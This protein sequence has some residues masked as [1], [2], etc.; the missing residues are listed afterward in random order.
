MRRQLAKAKL[1]VALLALAI[2]GCTGSPTEVS[3][4]EPST[5]QTSDT[6]ANA[7]TPAEA[8]LALDDAVDAFMAQESV[9]FTL[10]AE[11]VIDDDVTKI[12]GSGVWT[13]KPLAWKSTLTY[14][15]PRWAQDPLS[16]ERELD[17]IYLASRPLSVYSRATYQG[18]PKLPWGVWPGL[19]V[20]DGVTRADL[21][22]PPSIT[23]L[24]S[25][26]S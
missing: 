7:L 10:R 21:T 13:S 24:L 26:A 15:S 5:E 4:P 14:D 9:G 19:G 16:H 23:M 1:A 17:V 18:F 6:N 20:R 2:S 3:A 22:T 8:Q 25:A 12:T 11:N